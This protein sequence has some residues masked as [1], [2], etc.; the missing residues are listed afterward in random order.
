VVYVVRVAAD[1][2]TAHNGCGAAGRR[3]TFQVAGVSMTSN[4]LWDNTDVAYLPLTRDPYMRFLPLIV[5]KMSFPSRQ[6][7]L[8][9]PLI[10]RK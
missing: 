10:V 9:L 4:A 1:D 2:G 7:H 3:V 6:G 5:Q 8:F